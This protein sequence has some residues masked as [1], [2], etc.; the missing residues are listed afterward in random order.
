MLRSRDR[1]LSLR[2]SRVVG[3][4]HAQEL[5][6]AQHLL[7]VLDTGVGVVRALPAVIEALELDRVAV[8]AASRVL[9]VDR[10]LDAVLYRLTADCT[11]GQVGPDLDGALG[12]RG[13]TRTAAREG[14]KCRH[15]EDY[16]SPSTNHMVPPCANGG[17]DFALD[18]SVI[19]R[20]LPSDAGARVRRRR[21][22]PHGVAEPTLRRNYRLGR[23]SKSSCVWNRSRPV[24]R[25]CVPRCINMEARRCNPPTRRPATA[26][27]DRAAATRRW[28]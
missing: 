23:P 4:D 27:S 17:L 7:D 18:A 14:D 25:W 24:R 10:E 6:V 21:M 9:L 15:G 11:H 3:A 5:A 8:D 1:N 20:P 13:P 19:R 2:H 26:Q 16:E 12:S 22:R 28:R